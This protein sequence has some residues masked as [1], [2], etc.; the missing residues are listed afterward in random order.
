MYYFSDSQI[1]YKS[2]KDH[3]IDQPKEEKRDSPTM[4]PNGLDSVTLAAI[5]GSVAIVC[6][7]IVAIAVAIMFLKRHDIK[8]K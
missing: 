7:T 3:D 6:V 2:S 5:L 8:K 1:N 4:K